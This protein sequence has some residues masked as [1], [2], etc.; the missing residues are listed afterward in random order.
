MRWVS[1][2]AQ[3]SIE[4]LALKFVDLLHA[5]HRF[6]AFLDEVLVEG[7]LCL[8]SGETQLFLVGRHGVFSEIDDAEVGRNGVSGQVFAPR[9]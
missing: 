5:F 8:K 4:V 3:T 7:L 9:P 6:L 1:N 2:T